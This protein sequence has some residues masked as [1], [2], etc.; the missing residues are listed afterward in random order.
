MKK[1]LVLLLLGGAIWH[2]YL[3]K[4]QSPVITNIADD[5]SLLSSPVIRHASSSPFPGAGA[6]SSRVPA[7]ASAP[8]PD[9]C[10][11]RTHCSQMTSCEEAIYFLRNCPG[12]QMDGDNDGVPCESQWCRW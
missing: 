11:G 12:T 1:L 10:D 4:P 7:A 3:N 9:R 8:R 2:F 5:G 6:P